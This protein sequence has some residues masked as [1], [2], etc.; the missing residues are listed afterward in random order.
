MSARSLRGRPRIA[1]AAAILGFALVSVAALPQGQPH[2][3]RRHVV[4]ISGVAFHPEVLEVGWGD[5]VVWINQDLV[6]HTA[7]AEGAAAWTT[8][9]LATGDSGQFIPHRAGEYRY[10]CKFHPTMH[11]KLIVR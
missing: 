10:V 1:A 5:T 9:A 2:A 3:A 6:P 11:G 8:A 4:E 7:T